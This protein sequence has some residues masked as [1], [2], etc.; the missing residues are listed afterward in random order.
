LLRARED[1]RRFLAQELHDQ[2]GQ[3]LTGLRLQLEAANADSPALKAPIAL[4]DELLRTVRELTLQLRPRIL[5]DLGLCP[6]LE[7]HTRRFTAQTGIAVELDLSL[8][9]PRPAPELEIVVYRLV[10]EA[11]TN[12]AR[13]SGAPSASVSVTADATT[14]HVEISDRGRGCDAAVA[15]AR[16]D[17]LG[18]AG[19][20]ERVRLAAGRFEF[21]SHPGQGT[22]LHAEF[23]LSEI[24]PL[25]T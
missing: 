25:S 8:P 14:L 18:L 15:L 7:W 23:P 22:R 5:D 24:L 16:R 10:Q 4:T 11:L 3:L 20:A 12:T 17:S 6:A 2:I 9:A 1:E 21:V 13:H 19:A